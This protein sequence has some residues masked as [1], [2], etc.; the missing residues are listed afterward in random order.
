MAHFLDSLKD[1]NKLRQSAKEIENK[2]R[3]ERLDYSAGNGQVKLVINGKLEIL[4][5]EVSPELLD[6]DRKQRTEKMI[7]SAVNEAIQKM[8]SRVS[9]VIGGQMGFDLPGM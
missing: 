8:Q 1:L 5:L 3:Q 2:L 6:A 9:K 4:S 7:L